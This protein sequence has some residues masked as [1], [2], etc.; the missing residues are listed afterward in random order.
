[1]LAIEN[2]DIASNHCLILYFIIASYCISILTKNVHH[3]CPRLYQSGNGWVVKSKV[4]CP[5]GSWILGRVNPSDFPPD[6]SFQ[7][8]P[9]NETVSWMYQDHIMSDFSN[10]GEGRGEIISR[11]TGAR[12]REVCRG[13]CEGKRDPLR[14]VSKLYFSLSVSFSGAGL[15][16]CWVNHQCTWCNSFHLS[17]KH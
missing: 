1:M 3:F 12:H 9:K 13:N 16:L 7:F 17:T 11:D 8:Y 6:I 15:V 2:E 5:Q 14:D 10:W 4:I